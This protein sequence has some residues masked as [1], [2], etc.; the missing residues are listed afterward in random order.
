MDKEMVGPV[1]PMEDRIIQAMVN[2]ERSK[3]QKVIVNLSHKA[4]VAMVKTHLGI[5]TN[6]L[7]SASQQLRLTVD[8]VREVEAMASRAP[9]AV[10]VV[11]TPEHRRKELVVAVPAMASRAPMV[12]R[13]VVDMMAARAKEVEV[14]AAVAM[15]DGVKV[16]VAVRAE[17]L[18]AMVETAQKEVAASGAEAAVASI[19]AV[20]TVVV[21]L[22]VGAMTVAVTT[23]V[24][25]VDL[26]VWGSRD[27]GSRDESGGDQDNSDN[28]TIFVQGLGEDATVQEVGDFFK[29]IG[30]IKVNKK[31]GQPMINIYS[32]KATGRP[33]GEATVS[34]DDPPSA[35][36]AIDWFDGKEFNGKPI[37]VSFATRRAEF[38]QRG[39]FR[40]GRGGFRGRGGGGGP[41]FDIKGGDWPCP[42]S[43]CGNMNFAR[44]QE[45]NK[46]G[47]PK[48]EDAGFGGGDRG[49][50]RGGFG[51][52]RGGGFRGRGGFRGGDRGGFGGGDRGFGGGYKMGG[53]GDRRDDRRDRPY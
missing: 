33:K 1:V 42:N 3:L 25:E 9:T 24:A 18:A 37:K 50:G 36:A 20:T 38:T 27:Y 34:F 10:R 43:S 28:N 13:A 2:K 23:V 40:G 17:G 32:D 48:P 11:A 39:G 30:I 8:R 31:T 35:K 19:V 7:L 22:T 12:D 53:R 4:M 16:K 14:A 47:A 15:E 46:C 21:A 51:G 49:G 41:N 6:R 5:A 26:L 45:C 44:R 52:D 29:Q